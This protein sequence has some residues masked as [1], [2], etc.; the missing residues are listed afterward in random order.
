MRKRIPGLEARRCARVT[1]PI[2]LCESCERACPA[3][4]IG[5]PPGGAPRIDPARCS[6]CG[7]CVAACPE[8]AFVSPVPPPEPGERAWALRCAGV[9]GG[10]DYCLNAISLAELALAAGVGVRRIEVAQFD[11]AGCER[12]GAVPF[13]E[14]LA[15]FNALARTRGLRPL[16]LVRRPRRKPG[17]FSRLAAP[18]PPDAGRRALF[19][20]GAGDPGQ[21]RA[22]ALRRFL[23]TRR[24]GARPHFPFAPEIDPARC[25][26]CDACVRG[27]PSE[28]LRL[29]EGEQPAYEIDASRCT[30]CGWCLALC[31]DDA[32]AIGIDAPAGGP[33]ALEPF[34]C[35]ACKAPSHRPARGGEE[36][37]ELCNI[38]EKRQYSRPDILV[39]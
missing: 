33:V 34:R 1:L 39:L 38:C 14:T 30:G 3:E 24:K 35:S 27:C 22:D 8:Q 31:E 21:E 37:W 11:C 7:A 19:H 32:I 18:A 36:A 26:G 4:A 10:G 28:A 29:G 2:P 13:T 5:L 9:A 16:E 20:Q 12:K 6:G 25:S 15:R 17:L 23:G